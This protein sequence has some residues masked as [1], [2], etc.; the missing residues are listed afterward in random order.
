M[1]RKLRTLI[2]TSSEDVTT[3]LLVEALGS[4]AVFRFNTDLIDHY[5]LVLSPSRE[6]Q[7]SDPLGRTITLDDTAKLYWRKP[8]WPELP[9]AS[10]NEVAFLREE[11][12]CLSLDLFNL[13][14]Y[15]GLA[16]LV[17]PH[18]QRRL[19]KLLQLRVASR[20]F[21]VPGTA[22]CLPL[23]QPSFSADG[24]VVKSLSGEQLRDYRFLYTTRVELEELEPG[25]PWT[26]QEL[27]DSR[28]DVTVVAFGSSCFAF[29][30]DRTFLGSADWR[31][32]LN[33]PK[34]VWEPFS[35]TER[36][37]SSIRKFMSD[38]QLRFGRLD[39]LVKDG[40]LVFLE[41]NPNGQFAWLDLDR[42]N[43][44]MDAVLQ[45]LSPETPIADH[46]RVPSPAGPR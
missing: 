13:A 10:E 46:Y 24:F 17:D 23:S 44:L 20:Y 30:L 18:A 15:A 5:Q 26:I 35:L 38:C 16:V 7:I 39:F 21:T 22:T 14:A 29:A 8:L 4:E 31:R 3:D 32:Q 40:E 2:V 28:I 34:C 33:D 25:A 43:G 41:V 27:I 12:K 37:E 19:G 45:V 42:A 6:L 11:V 36:Q 9:G 1:A